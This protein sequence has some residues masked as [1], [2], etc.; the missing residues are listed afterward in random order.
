[1]FPPP[2]VHGGGGEGYTTHSLGGEEV[3]AAQFRRGVRQCGTLGIFVL[4]DMI[5]DLVMVPV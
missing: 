3:G 1:V 2:L 4:C 5:A